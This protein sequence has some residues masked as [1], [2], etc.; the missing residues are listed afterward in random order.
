MPASQIGLR[1]RVRR[2]AQQTAEQHRQ[3]DALRRE[4][5]AALERDARADGRHAL[6]R[7]AAALAA[8]FEL[9]QAVFFPAL[10]GLSPSRT[11]ELE[12]LEREHGGFLAELQRVR[13]EI[14]TAPADASAGAFARFL[15]GLGGHEQREE[16]LVGVISGQS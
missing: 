5:T 11:Q 4:V 1:H 8:H 15:T 7:F 13:D 9:E 3:L 16:R 6:E 10:H 2:L 12:A 14:A